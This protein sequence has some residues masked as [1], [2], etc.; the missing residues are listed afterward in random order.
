MKLTEKQENVLE[1]IRSYYEQYGYAP[2]FREVSNRFGV[3]LRAGRDYL[4]ALERKGYIG[5]TP[6]V[7]RSIV[8]K[9]AG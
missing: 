4:T 2:S 9:K 8:I 5:M 1:F 3:S 6:N 7:A